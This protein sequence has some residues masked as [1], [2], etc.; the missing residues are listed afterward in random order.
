MAYA[1]GKGSPFGATAVVLR[2]AACGEGE[3]RLAARGEG[4]TRLAA[5]GEGEDA[6]EVRVELTGPANGHFNAGMLQLILPDGYTSDIVNPPTPV[7]DELFEDGVYLPGTILN[8]RVTPATPMPELALRFQGCVDAMCYMP[9][10]ISLG[11][12]PAEDSPGPQLPKQEEFSSWYRGFSREQVCFGYTNAEEFT[13]WLDAAL[14]EAT[15]PQRENLLTRVAR[16]HGLWLAVLLVIPLGLLLNL[17]PCVLPMIPI[18]LAVLGAKSAGAGR[19][20]G[21]A[22]GAIY[23]G[24]MA[25]AYGLVGLVFVKIGGRFGSV[26]ASPWFNCGVGIVFVCLGLSMFDLFLV[27]LTRFRKATSRPGGGFGTAAFLGAMSALLAGACV[28]PVLIWVLLFSTELYSG[29][30]ALGLWL[31][32]LLGIGLGL[33]WPFLGGGLGFLPKP[34]AWMNRVKQGFGVLILLFACYYFWNGI[35]LFR[36]SKTA[37]EEDGYW[38]TDIAAAVADARELH[39][40]LFVDFWGVTCKACDTMDA[41][42]LRD[43]QVRKRLDQMIRIKIQA[44]DFDDPMLA[45][46]LQHFNILG[47]PAYVVLSP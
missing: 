47:L 21:V 25:L 27:D 22:L 7:H 6:L 35:Q 34:G 17:T 43:P 1:Q 20:R 5:R 39:R 23:G 26:N 28:A 2:L 44:D 4:K 24:A 3:T 37:P 46:V 15:V 16:N 45:P 33:P 10:T 9:Q 38:Q 42:T 14:G 19:R 36:S 32:F 11:G 40:P 18:T 29:G 41:T 13:A 30:N 31:P 8:Y 12:A